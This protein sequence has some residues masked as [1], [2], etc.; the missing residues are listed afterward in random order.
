MNYSVRIFSN[1]VLEI[2][3]QLHV[4][5]MQVT[6]KVNTAKEPP[7]WLF[8]RKNTPV[9]MV[10]EHLKSASNFYCSI[11]MLKFDMRSYDAN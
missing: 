8:L 3:R 1:S 5:F 9:L 6:S 4:W 7:K 11:F 2:N 10:V